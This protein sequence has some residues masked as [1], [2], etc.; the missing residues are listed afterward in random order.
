[1]DLFTNFN[2]F[3][4]NTR[5]SD[6]GPETLEK[7]K[8]LFYQ[9][10]KENNQQYDITYDVANPREDGVEYDVA[11]LKSNNIIHIAFASSSDNATDELDIKFDYEYIL[12]KVEQSDEFEVINVT[13][14]N[15]I[16]NGQNIIGLSN[17]LS[18]QVE[19]LL[20]KKYS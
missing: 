9:L 18:Q 6:A 11:D 1:M 13:I 3:L 2:L 14:L 7:V 12:H 15:A 8:D 19:K 10:N 20:L 4:E 17:F 16:Y 5:S